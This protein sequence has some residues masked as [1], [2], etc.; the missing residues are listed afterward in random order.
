MAG[1]A[2]VMTIFTYGII[3]IF[4]AAVLSLIL[5]SLARRKLRDEGR[6]DRGLIVKAA[7]APFLGLAWLVVA[8]LIHVQ[9]SNRLAHQDCGLSGDPYVTLPNGYEVGSHNTY[10]GYIRAP[11][12]Q[13]DVPIAGPG[14]VRSIINLHLADDKFTG[15]QFD[16]KT[17]SVRRFTF[18]THTQVF[19]S[20]L[21]GPLS[22]DAANDKAQL[23]DESY[24]KI[25]ARYRH[26]WPTYVL[27]I[28]IV[29]GEGAIGLWIRRSWTTKPSLSLEDHPT[30]FAP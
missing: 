27:L 26:R 29:A 6:T 1:F 5:F 12:S 16:F 21:E 25:Y 10:D 19:Q 8:L 2:V 17:S 4:S 9:V 14:Y 7:V 3:G 11:G 22:W 24:W 20:A 30:S 28:L 13:T 18:D 23:G 15:T